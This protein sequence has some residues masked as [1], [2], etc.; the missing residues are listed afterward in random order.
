MEEEEVRMQ[1]CTVQAPQAQRVMTQGGGAA[2][3]EAE[4]LG[5]GWMNFG[6]RKVGIRKMDDVGAQKVLGNAGMISGV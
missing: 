5:L 2:G 3:E 4:K 1:K 6:G